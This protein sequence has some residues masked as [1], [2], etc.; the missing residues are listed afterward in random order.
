MKPA[1]PFRTQAPGQPSSLLAP[2]LL[3]PLHA[4]STH[5]QVKPD[6]QF[7]SEENRHNS[8]PSWRLPKDAPQPHH[9]FKRQCIP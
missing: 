8:L 3:T 5:L 1:L 2:L 6:L 4:S 9:L 7:S